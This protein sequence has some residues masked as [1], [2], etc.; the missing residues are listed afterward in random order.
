MDLKKQ[1]FE[2]EQKFIIENYRTMK[3]ADIARHLGIS[4]GAV[5]S[6]IGRLR[7]AGVIRKKNRAELK[8][9]RRMEPVNITYKGNPNRFERNKKYRIIHWSVHKRDFVGTYRGETK[10]VHIFESDAKYMECFLKTD[11][12]TGE[13]KAEKIS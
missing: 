1:R 10:R 13:Y 12:M 3:Y 7:E 5:N 6:R 4:P 9:P 8:A 11:F 2:R